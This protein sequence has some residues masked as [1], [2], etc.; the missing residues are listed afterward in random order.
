MNEMIS[1]CGL[2]CHE[3]PAFLATHSND[4]A[5][6]AEIAAQWS[7][8]YHAEIKPK[9]INCDGCVS[10]SGRLISHGH[11]CEIRKCGIAKEI[12]NCGFCEDYACDKL[13]QIFKMAPDAKKRLDEIHNN[14]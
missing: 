11:V 4:D 9:D 10:T 14:L 8:E 6:R 1:M 2:A 12:K 7:K 5:K 13:E 3:C